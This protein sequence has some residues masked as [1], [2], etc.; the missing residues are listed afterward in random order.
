MCGGSARWLFGMRFGKA[1]VDIDR[2]LQ[3]FDNLN[4]LSSGLSGAF[5]S[6]AVNHILGLEKYGERYDHIICSTYMQQQLI[7]RFRTD[8]ILAAKQLSSTLEIPGFAGIVFEADF[9]DRVKNARVRTDSVLKVK[10]RGE[11]GGGIEDWD[12]KDYVEYSGSADL[13]RIA[14]EIKVGTWLLPNWNQGCF[15]AV[16]LLDNKRLRFVQV[17][18]RK[19]HSLLLHHAAD[20]INTLVELG[21]E[22]ETID[23]VFLVPE[24][25]DRP[26]LDKP[27]GDLVGPWGEWTRDDVRFLWLPG[28]AESV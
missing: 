10:V 12:A 18:A 28:N 4:V 8:L 1:K 24:G 7:K 21:F 17:T 27:V 3:R 19:S 26:K 23:F 6:T 22:I 13:R 9:V 15:D 20:L 16:Q 14:K 11:S 25:K 5:V 2:Y